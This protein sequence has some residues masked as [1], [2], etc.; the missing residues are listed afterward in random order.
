MKIGVIG[1]GLMGRPIGQRLLDA[2]FEVGVYN[3]T[4]AKTQPLVEAGARVAR[5]PSEAIGD[6]EFVITMLSDA[7]AIREVLLTPDA[8]EAV[9][10]RAVIQMSTIAPAESLELAE[11]ITE[12]G[13]DYLEAPVLGSVPQ[14]ESGELIIMTG[15]P[16]E[17]AEAAR[18]VLEVLGKRIEHIGA[19]GTAAAVKLAL[20]QMIAGLTATFALSLA[21]V[22]REGCDVEQFMRI[23]RDSALYAPTFD[24]KLPMML[25]GKYAPVNFPLRHL[26]KDMRLIEEEATRFGLTTS[27]LEATLAQ[28][29]AAHAKHET[30]QDYSA[31]YDAVDANA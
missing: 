24:K 12:A 29:E 13:G 18:A 25:A 26:I 19:V 4:K 22:Q 6:C 21:V 1:T 16:T 15:G 27:V 20:N 2:G 30:D 3:R 10:D 28:L 5:G 31:I 8:L 17:T 9:R 23:L 14:A 7:N 11:R